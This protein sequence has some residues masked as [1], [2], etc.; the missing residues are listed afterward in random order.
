MYMSLSFDGLVCV[1]KG[2][3]PEECFKKTRVS[4]LTLN[5][6]ISVENGT[7]C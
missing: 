3:R 6:T 2:L 1:I 5:V 4:A 7:C